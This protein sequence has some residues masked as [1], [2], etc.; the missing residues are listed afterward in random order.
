MN[1][2]WRYLAGRF[3]AWVIQK[4]YSERS[5]CRHEVIEQTEEGD[6]YCRDCGKDMT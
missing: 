3:A 2:F 5:T 1:T 6:L 4:V